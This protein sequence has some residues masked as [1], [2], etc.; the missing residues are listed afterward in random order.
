VHLGPEGRI[1]AMLDDILPRLA[2]EEVGRSDDP[3]RVVTVGVERHRAELEDSPSN[4][5]GRH[6]GPGRDDDSST[7]P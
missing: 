1:V 5:K 6:Y 2:V 7:F 4:E 3:H